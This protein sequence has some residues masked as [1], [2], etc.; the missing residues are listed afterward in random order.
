MQPKLEPTT[1]E[2]AEAVLAWL[3][4]EGSQAGRDSMARFAIPSDHAVGV[5]VGRLRKYAKQLRTDHALAA[6]LWASGVHEARLLATFIDDP[7]QVSVAQMDRWVSDFDNWAICDTACFALFDHV[8]QAWGRL[9]PWARRRDEFGKRAAFA[10]LW[11]LSVH[12]KH[13]GDPAFLDAL[14]LIE[15]A[16]TDERH[17]VKKAVNMALRAV[18]KRND[19]LHTACAALAQRLAAADDATARWIGKHALQELG[20]ASVTRRL[21]AKRGR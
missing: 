10:L 7:A 8:P 13:A 14:P 21:A 16:A 3:Q 2:K 5:S 20:G 11:S 17:F 12:D 18:G 9:V 1:A 4:R 19:V 6:A 15:A